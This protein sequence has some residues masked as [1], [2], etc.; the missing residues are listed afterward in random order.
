MPFGQ[1]AMI[2]GAKAE[3][4]NEKEFVKVWKGDIEYRHSH[5]SLREGRL[6][7]E[8][9]TLD[10]WNLWKI[11]AAQ[12]VLQIPTYTGMMGCKFQTTFTFVAARQFAV[13]LG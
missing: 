11:T 2:R 10:F 9:N 1:N 7:R 12:R 3:A 4:R 5:P 8:S 13:E 6:R